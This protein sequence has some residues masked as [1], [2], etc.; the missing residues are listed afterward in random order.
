MPGT[1]EFPGPEVTVAGLAQVCRLVER[2]V[3]NLR[4]GRKGCRYRSAALGKEALEV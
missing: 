3:V 2:L 1:R 4:S